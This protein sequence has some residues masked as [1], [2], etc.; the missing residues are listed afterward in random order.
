MK[1]FLS[2]I[3]GKASIPA[4][5]QKEVN[6]DEV[7]SITEIPGL[8]YI[9]RSEDRDEIRDLKAA[10]QTPGK[11]V[12]IHGES[13]SGKTT[14]VR[15]LAK[16]EGFECVRVEGPEIQG[17]D[18]FWFELGQKLR[19]AIQEVISVSESSSESASVAT[20][21]SAKLW[22]PINSLSS[23]FHVEQLQERE[24]ELSQHNRPISSVRQTVID[25]LA[26]GSIWVVV[27]DF[28]M[29][30]RGKS[31]DGSEFHEPEKAR[32]IRHSIFEDIK[33][34]VSENLAKFVFISIP[35]EPIDVLS[36]KEGFA[37]DTQL[38]GRV[39]IEEFPGWSREEL[40]RIPTN[41]FDLLGMTI[42]KQRAIRIATASL[43][44]PLNAHQICHRLC[45]NAGVRKKSD[46][47]ND[48]KGV[49]MRQVKVAVQD[50]VR[51]MDL[52]DGYCDKILNVG[53]GRSG[54][55]VP[56][57]NRMVN[58]NEAI[59]MGLA[60]SYI[61][62]EFGLRVDKLKSRIDDLFPSNRWNETVIVGR[63][64]QMAGAQIV[65]SVSSNDEFDQSH[66]PIIFDKE[67]L[68]V[69]LVDPG[70][71]MYLHEKYRRDFEHVN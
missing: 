2:R 60:K 25:T 34:L 64:E 62:S 26:D 41:G 70:L 30:C 29:A 16:S 12:C 43:G 39:S 9:D 7:F 44:S 22:S 4:G 53:A 21:V 32:R 50:F 10:L 51:S 52:Y 13:K 27:D 38:S 5:R 18:T 56:F 20:G 36:S 19:A 35:R 47:A 14:F 42:V 48:N 46:V 61:H 59:A 71:S 69:F 31:S 15:E 11:L 37:G 68:K 55:T 58:L 17:V 67:A 49:S 3:I 8:N 66:Q 63:L 40:V 24:R 65:R 33:S 1:R 28:H 57:R 23:R 6:L 45:L 54:A